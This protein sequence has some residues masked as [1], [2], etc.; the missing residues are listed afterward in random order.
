[1]R[2]KRLLVCMASRSAIIYNQEWENIE[3]NTGNHMPFV[4]P[5][6]QATEH[7]TKSV[8]N[9]KQTQAVGDHERR[10]ETE[11]PERLQP[12]KEGLTRESHVRQTYSHLTRPYHLQKFLLPRILQKNLLQ[13]KQEE[14]TTY[15]LTL[16]QRPEL[17]SMQTHESCK[18]AMQKKS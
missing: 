17:R 16:S 13:T 7:Q 5:G 8:G 6:V 15:S 9:R 1:M 18:G 4:V 3:C 11:L 2:R 10:V 12:F 14:S